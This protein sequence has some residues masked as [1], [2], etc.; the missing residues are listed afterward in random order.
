MTAAYRAFVAERNDL[1]VVTIVCDECSSSAS[2]NIETARVPVVCGSCG[3][4]YSDNLGA[5]LAGLARFHRMGKTAEDA[6]GKPIFQFH[7]KQKD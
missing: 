4:Q 2:I 1:I 7:I 6:A 5:A 3:K